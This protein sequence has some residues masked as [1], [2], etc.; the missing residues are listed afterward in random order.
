M[1]LSAGTA[2]VDITPP[3][4]L[5]LGCWAA[6]SALAQG[7]REGLQAQALVLSDGERTTA[8]LATDLVFVS[9]NL[10]ATVRERV[11]DLTGI[12]PG[13]LSVHASHN[14]SAPSLSHGSSVAGGTT[15]IPAFTRYTD[16]LG[17][18]L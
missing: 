6:R 9:A 17:D 18:R 13:A 1:S 10:A 7:A 15:D 16:A 5:P 2:R 12:P 14:H 11:V 8:V 4:G 3:L